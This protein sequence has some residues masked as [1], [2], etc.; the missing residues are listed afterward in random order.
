MNGYAIVWRFRLPD[1]RGDFLDDFDGSGHANDA[2]GELWVIAVLKQGGSGASV[3]E[4]GFLFRSTISVPV[5]V[6]RDNFRGQVHE[7]QSVQSSHSKVG[8]VICGIV[9][10]NRVPI[11]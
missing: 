5:G 11:N 3:R 9:M 1:T 2:R 4:P 8:G 7:H 10:S 6:V